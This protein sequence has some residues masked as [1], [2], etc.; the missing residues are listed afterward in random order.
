MA[1]VGFLE[2]EEDSAHTLFS[3]YGRGGTWAS[4]ARPQT[5]GSTRSS[6]KKS[7]R[8]SP[9]FPAGQSSRGTPSTREL[10]GDLGSLR[11]LGLKSRSEA[12]LPGMPFPASPAKRGARSN[13]ATRGL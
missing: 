2:V 5:V 10:G 4:P 8:R 13:V 11:G 9:L 6:P 1:A 12:T 3:Q 7:A